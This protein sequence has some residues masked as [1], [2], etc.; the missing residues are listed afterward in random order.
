M[1]AYLNAMLTAKLYHH[2]LNMYYPCGFDV[3]ADCNWRIENLIN[4]FLQSYK[5]ELKTHTFIL[6]YQDDTISMICYRML[7]AISA[8]EPINLIVYGKRRKTKKMMPKTQKRVGRLGLKRLMKK[9]ENIIFISAFNPLYKVA[10][11]KNTFNIF[12]YPT[13]SPI[14]SFTPDQL[15]TLRVFYHIDY[16]K[17]DIIDD[18]IITKS[19]QS[20]CEN[21]LTGVSQNAW[22][23]LSLP[24]SKEEKTYN[25][26]TIKVV[27]LTSDLE[28]NKILLQDVENTDAIV[29][30]ELPEVDGYQ[31]NQI[32][33]QLRQYA[34]FIKRHSNAVGYYNLIGNGV[35]ISDYQEILPNIKIE[36]IK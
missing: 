36:Y 26:D 19:F 28:D 35:N 6:E 22:L 16:I 27:S 1:N 14:K 29:L 5:E 33:E 2:N 24:F 15:K 30:Y 13:W 34:L 21:H 8:I 31:H 20:W 32:I 9:E 10:S 11:S 3:E 4:D 25:E 7:K 23:D 18:K 17:N 12:N